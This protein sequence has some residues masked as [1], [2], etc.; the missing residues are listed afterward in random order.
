[1]RGSLSDAQW[2]VNPL[3]PAPLPLT[4][5]REL[6]PPSGPS[7]SGDS[8]IATP[9]ACIMSR[10][11]LSGAGVWGCR[12]PPAGPVRRCRA[13][14]PRRPAGL[15]RAKLPSKAQQ[16][17]GDSGAAGSRCSSSLRARCARNCGETV[18]A[19]PRALRR[20]GSAGWHPTVSPSPP[21][22]A[23]TLAGVV[24]GSS[25]ASR[26]AACAIASAQLH[27]GGRRGDARSVAAGPRQ[28]GS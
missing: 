2:A 22:D 20:R 11:A 21:D 19:R 12:R 16:A 4:E 18:S 7:P 23:N 1:M 25:P 17:G 15:R 8:T 13:S 6:F 24:A 3:T 28:A 5:E 27:G 10:T 14:G 26:N 9:N